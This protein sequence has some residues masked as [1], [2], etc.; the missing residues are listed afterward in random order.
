MP[1]FL[2]WNIARQPISS[3]ISKLALTHEAD[4]IILAE[5]DIPGAELLI[6]LNQHSSQYQLPF[7]VCERIQVFTRFHSGFLSPVYEDDYTSI[8]KLNLPGHPELL[9]VMTHLPS[10]LYQNPGSRSAACVELARLIANEEQRAGHE[11]TIVVG[12]L[13]INPFEPGMIS[14]TGLNAVMTKGIA[15]AGARTVKRRSYPLFYNPM[16]NLFGDGSGGPGGTYFYGRAEHE[17]HF[18]HLFDQVLLRPSLVTSF[19]S[20]DLRILTSVNGLNLLDSRGQPDRGVASDHL[21]I[22]F[23]LNSWEEN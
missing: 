20:R 18:W 15:A 14:S 10:G 8:R 23:S 7:G 3:L 16:W 12:D 11:R 6:A 22:I 5:S 13:N 1:T 4:V 2:F 21:P 17:T 19:P 9:L